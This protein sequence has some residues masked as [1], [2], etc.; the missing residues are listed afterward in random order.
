LKEDIDNGWDMAVRSL[1][2]IRIIKTQRSRSTHSIS[3]FKELT[4]AIL[5][6]PQDYFVLKELGIDNLLC[7]RGDFTLFQSTSLSSV[8]IF[9]HHQHMEFRFNNAYKNKST[10]LGFV[11][12]TAI[13]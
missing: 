12:S 9:Q 6:Y 5:S 7:L 11:P 13:F 1:L 2:H 8:T 10:L 4:V 3:V